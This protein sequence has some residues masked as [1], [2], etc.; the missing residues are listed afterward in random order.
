MKK[1]CILNKIGGI[2]LLSSALA[3]F[4]CAT[5]GTVEPESEDTVVVEIPFGPTD[6]DLLPPEIA[7]PDSLSPR[8]QGK[9]KKKATSLVNFFMAN[10]PDAKKPYVKKLAKLYISEANTE[11]IN[12]DVAFVQMCLETGFLRFGNLVQP[13]QHNYCGLGAT[14]PGH[15]GLSFKTPKQGVRA[16]IQHLH[17][18]GTTEEFVLKNKLLDTRYRYVNPRGKAPTIFELAG[19]WAADRAYGE[20]LSGLLKKLEK[21]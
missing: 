6:Q 11:G 15:P 21:Y 10:N 8:I 14:G 2:A 20:K 3:L 1:N 18:Y 12:S 7:E 5:T 4:S 13:E 19:T 9:G 17:A 16:H